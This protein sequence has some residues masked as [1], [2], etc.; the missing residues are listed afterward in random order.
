MFLS[1]SS[2]FML[3]R[4]KG[5]LI[6]LKATA[7]ATFSLHLLK[8]PLRYHGKTKEPE[9]VLISG[10]LDYDAEMGKLL[11][12]TLSKLLT[13]KCTKFRKKK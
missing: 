8:M 4:N 11:F 7:Y 1:R 12:F 2:F 9:F 3:I 10:V 5:K 6:F 13:I